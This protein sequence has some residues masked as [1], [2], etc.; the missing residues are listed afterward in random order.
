MKFEVTAGG[1]KWQWVVVNYGQSLAHFMSGSLCLDITT[2]SNYDM[3]SFLQH[4]HNRYHK[5]LLS[6][7]WYIEPC[8]N[9][10]QQPLEINMKYHI[11]L[12]IFIHIHWFHQRHRSI[13]L[14]HVYWGVS[15][16]LYLLIMIGPGSSVPN[17]C[18]SVSPKQTTLEEDWELF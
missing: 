8:Y 14:P 13:Y 18:Q 16:H 10:A 1:L 9:R 7:S 11:S 6:V 5:A 4:S 12:W 3:I 17:Y 15:V 2:W